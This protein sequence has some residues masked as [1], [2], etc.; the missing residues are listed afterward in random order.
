MVCGKTYF[1]TY[2]DFIRPTNRIIWWQTVVEHRMTWNWLSLWHF[3]SHNSRF[4]ILLNFV[5]LNIFRWYETYCWNIL[6]GYNGVHLMTSTRAILVHWIV[7][8]YESN[9]FSK[10]S[11]N[12]FWKQIPTKISPHYAKY[13]RFVALMLIF[14]S[15]ALA[16]AVLFNIFGNNL[17]T[18][19]LLRCNVSRKILYFII[20]M[21]FLIMKRKATLTGI[22]NSSAYSFVTE[23]VL[24]LNLKS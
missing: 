16:T 4:R 13:Q 17:I 19:I 7:P 2:F 9:S 10:M 12:V 6:R 21:R 8:V 5:K 23:I 22:L 14:V 20:L 24:Q 11:N 18:V 15:I 1:R 3:I